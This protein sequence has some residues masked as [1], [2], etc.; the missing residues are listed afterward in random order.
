VRPSFRRKLSKIRSISLLLLPHHL[1]K[2]RQACN[3]PLL[4][5]ERIEKD[6]LDHIQDQILSEKNVRKYT[7]LV[8]EQARSATAEPSP[9]ENV[10]KL[11][12]AD[13]EARIRRWEEALERGLLS[14]E[15]SA[16]RIKELRAEREALLKN[17]VELEKKSRSAAT[18][19]PIPTRLM[20]DY[21]REMQIRLRDKKI[22]YKKEFLRELLQEVRIRDN[23]VTL[24]YKLPITARTPPAGGKIPQKEEFF[25]LYQMVELQFN[26]VDLQPTGGP[27][28]KPPISPSHQPSSP[29]MKR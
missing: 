21:I 6:V 22:G 24:S 12:I 16:H 28:P 10:A 17:K 15:D 1:Q 3:A 13:V 27:L 11:A 4:N 19:R 14:L 18:V 23:L 29:A 26:L 20:N 9:E 5:K 7:E 2:G 8:I 25:T